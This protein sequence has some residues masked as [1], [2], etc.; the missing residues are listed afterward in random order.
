MAI[1]DEKDIQKE[2]GVPADKKGVGGRFDVWIYYPMPR[3]GALDK[4]LNEFPG[5]YGCGVNHVEDIRE[6]SI[7]CGAGE[8]L[9]KLIALVPDDGYL[10]LSKNV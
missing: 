9:D 1:V 5:W 6:N 8:E 10:K 7:G 3:R 2:D 4:T